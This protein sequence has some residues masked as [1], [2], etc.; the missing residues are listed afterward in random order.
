MASPRTGTWRR[1]G[2]LDPV[3]KGDLPIREAQIVQETRTRVE[4]LVVPAAGYS[5]ETRRSLGERLAERLGPSIEVEVR[6]VERLER[7]RAGKLRSVVSK[8]PQEEVG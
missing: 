8:L 6:E 5:P 4:M 2:R 7:G 3:F 1:I